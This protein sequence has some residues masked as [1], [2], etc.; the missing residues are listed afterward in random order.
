MIAE[1][2]PDQLIGQVSGTVISFMLPAGIETHDASTRFGEL[3]G[4]D[5][6][7]SGRLVEAS[8]DQPTAAVHRLTG[9]AVEAGV[10]LDS[11]SVSRVSLE[12]VYLALTDDA[13]GADA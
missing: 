7:L 4:A 6:R 11:L 8:V 12:D 1:G 5:I 13:A 3:L 9:W 2:S 10:E